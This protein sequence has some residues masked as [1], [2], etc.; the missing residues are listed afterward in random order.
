MVCCLIAYQ[1]FSAFNQMF[2]R[3]ASCRYIRIKYSSK[4]QNIATENVH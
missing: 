2:L 3:R 1:L 4:I